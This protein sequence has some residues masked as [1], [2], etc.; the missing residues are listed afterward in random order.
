MSTDGDRALAAR[1]T[2]RPAQPEDFDYCARLYFE[3][4]ESAIRELGLDMDAQVAG[5]RQRWEVAQVR[6]ILLDGKDSGW[7]QTAVAED[8]LFLAQL[9]VDSAFRRLGIG[10]IVVK[11]LI[12]E[13]ARSKRA[14]TLGV[15]KANPARRLYERLGFRTT[16]EDERKFYMRHG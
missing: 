7:L 5:F 13:A 10:T 4:M 15:I 9:F 8:S 6:I 14:V 16:H 1:L 11:D 3:G 12:A 2:L